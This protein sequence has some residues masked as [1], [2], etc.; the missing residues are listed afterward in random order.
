LGLAL[1]LALSMGVTALVP[2]H[3]DQGAKGDLEIGPYVGYGF[4]DDYAGLNPKDDL[5]YGLRVGYFFTTHWSYEGSWQMFSSETE[6]ALPVLSGDFEIESVRGNML[7]NFRPGTSVR[8]FLTLGAGL[9]M[10]ETDSYTQSDIGFNAGA[11]V[12]WF[13]TDKFG[14]RFDGRYVYTDLGGAVD[15]AQSNVEA[16]LGV[17][18]SFGGRPPADTDGDGVPDKKDDCPD[19]PQGATVNEH[20]CP[21]DSDGDRVFDG[22]DKCPGTEPGLTVDS[23]GCPKDSDGDGVNDAYDKCPGTPKGVAVDASGCPKDSD[24][25]GVDDGRDKCPDTPK[26]VAVDASG[27]PKDSDG[28]G[29]DDAHDKCP[30]TAAGVKVDATGCPIPAPP[31]PPKPL[32]TPLVL[33]GVNFKTNSAELNATAEAILDDVAESLR[34]NPEVNVDISGYTDSTGSDAYNLKLSQGRADSVMRYL[35]SK[36]VAASRLTAKGYGE[37]KPVADNATPEGRARNR[38]V[39]LSRRK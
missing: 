20:G 37:A 3:A 29:V 21:A 10:N 16:T 27:C 13:F 11:G 14:M 5:L 18:W 25:D 36:G 35:V 6:P 33:E 23:V 9:E 8:P 34:A 1:G 30:G 12:R 2:S 22:I 19:T 7:Y 32:E 26:G 15:E 38:R 17:L 39:E 24:G 28:D 4:P 31:P